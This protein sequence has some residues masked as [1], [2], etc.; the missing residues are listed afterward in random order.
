MGLGRCFGGALFNIMKR[1]V[2]PKHGV[3]IP[4]PAEVPHMLAYGWLPEDEL[5]QPEIP[6]AVEDPCIEPV[7][8]PVKRGP[9][10]PRKAEQ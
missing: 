6:E 5:P 3:H 9:G 1:Y 4:H 10:R 8:P 2:H 7:Q